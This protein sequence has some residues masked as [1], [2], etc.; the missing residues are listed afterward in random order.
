MAKKKDDKPTM[1]GAVEL[2]EKDL[3]AIQGGAELDH[4]GNF[5]FKVEINGLKPR[6]TDEEL[7]VR[8]KQGSSVRSPEGT[9]L[10]K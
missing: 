1:A 10:R 2:E 3:D 9:K 8:A 5:N 7:S 4:V 6:L